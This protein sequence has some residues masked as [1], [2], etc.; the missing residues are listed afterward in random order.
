MRKACFAAVILLAGMAGPVR[1]DEPDPPA[2]AQGSRQ[3]R[4]DFLFGS[5]RVNVGIR[6]SWMWARAN[7]DWYEFV[8]DQLT[9][10]KG[11]FASSGISADVG[12][13]VGRR[14]E[15]VIGTDYGQSTAD[16]EFRDFVDNLRLP[17]EQ[18]TRIRQVGVTGG[19][20]YALTDRGRSV[21]SL[22]WVPRRVVPYVGGG[23]GML[24]FRMQQYGDFVDFQDFSVFSDLLQAS[25]WTPTAYVTGGMNL[26]LVSHVSLAFDAR[27][28]W[29][30]KDIGQRHPFK[31]DPDWQGFEPLDLSGL[32]FSTGIGLVF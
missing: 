7:S 20:R 18:T 4:P 21:S 2:A 26:Q 23:G 5:P 13:L 10:G 28:S 15:F 8:T 16:S 12:L 22:A 25:G 29:A 6:G 30:A 9:L 3:Q 14:V 11:D 1:A 27:Y 32:R 31:P 24:W 19:I 17:I